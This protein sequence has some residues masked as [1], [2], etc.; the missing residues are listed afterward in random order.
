MK[1][2]PHCC[3]VMVSRSGSQRRGPRVN[4]SRST[5]GSD[6]ECVKDK[7]RA[8]ELALRRGRFEGGE[9]KLRQTSPPLI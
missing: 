2:F 4:M 3:C 5:D 1:C 8:R 6:E 9:D 7:S